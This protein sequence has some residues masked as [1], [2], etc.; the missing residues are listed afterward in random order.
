MTDE[1]LEKKLSD[2]TTVE[3]RHPEVIREVIANLSEKYQ[4][5]DDEA[6]KRSIDLEMLS[7][8]YGF[9]LS[10]VTIDNC[11]EYYKQLCDKVIE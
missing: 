3:I 9:G 11:Y 7:H 8:L 1:P 4:K 2:Y 5:A 10:V 6:T